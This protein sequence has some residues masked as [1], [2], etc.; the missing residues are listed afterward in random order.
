MLYVYTYMF[1]NNTCIYP[2]QPTFADD[3]KRDL[4]ELQ[5]HQRAADHTRHKEGRGIP[6]A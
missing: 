1:T 6:P 4:D 2:H 5:A 3:I